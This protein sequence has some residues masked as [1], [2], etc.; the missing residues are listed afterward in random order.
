M[1]K[2]F[3]NLILAII[4]IL[5]ILFIFFELINLNIELKNLRNRHRIS[6]LNN[7]AS[8]LYVYSIRENQGVMPHYISNQFQLIGTQKN[9]CNIKCHNLKIENQECLNLTY[10]FDQYLLLH[11]YDPKGG[12]DE[13]TYYAIRKVNEEERL[14]LIACNSEN[15]KI[16]IV[17]K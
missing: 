13:I 9:N 4:D 8:S 15:E 2:F 1:K 3:L 16:I 11:P 6:D 7:I 5:I 10:M 17:K 12:S 14:E